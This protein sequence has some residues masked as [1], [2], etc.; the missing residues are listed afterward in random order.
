M[1]LDNLCVDE[2]GNLKI[3]D[4]GCSSTFDPMAPTQT[5]GICGS[6]P[7]IAPEVFAPRAV[8]DPRKVDVWA[9]GVIYLAM[10]SGHFPWE[11]ARAHDPNYALYLKYH[12]RVIDHWLP[13]TSAASPVVKAMLSIDPADR[14]TIDA[15]V[16]S[17]WIT[18]LRAKAAAATDDAALAASPVSAVS[19]VYAAANPAYSSASAV[20]SGISISSGY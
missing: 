8:Y 17:S 10:V 15:V 9:L 13:A 12:G 19:A 3:I 14:P 16:S 7:Y 6:D 11:V 20:S 4:F 1:K 5:R 18:G 2:E